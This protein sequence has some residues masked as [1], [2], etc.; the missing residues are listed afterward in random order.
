VRGVE[1]AGNLS[2][3]LNNIEILGEIAPKTIANS[4]GGILYLNINSS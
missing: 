3:C 2:C 4:L 1:I